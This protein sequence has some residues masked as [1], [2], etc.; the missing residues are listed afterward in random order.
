MRTL[1]ASVILATPIGLA[2]SSP[3]AAHAQVKPQEIPVVQVC[4]EDAT[5]CMN[6]A[7]GGTTAGTQV[8]GY[9]LN[10][11]N[12]DFVWVKLG[13]Y[14][15]AGV[16][17]LSCPKFGNSE[18]NDLYNG[19]PIGEI[20]SDTGNNLC[21]ALNGLLESCSA[22]GVVDVF[23]DCATL[24]DCMDSAVLNDYW[25]TANKSQRWVNFQAAPGNKIIID[26]SS[27]QY[28]TQIIIVVEKHSECVSG[29]PTESCS[30]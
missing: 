21:L 18:I 16:V 14:C 17:T 29:S 27:A 15:G 23:P 28:L 5:L 9:P 2:V 20:A 11:E 10:N 4:N 19:A 7:G 1:I 8:I 13:S 12:N 6:R 22:D 24:T 25:T 3:A 26:G 30:R